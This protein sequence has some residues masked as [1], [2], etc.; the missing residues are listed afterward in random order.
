LPT[1][2]EQLQMSVFMGCATREEDATRIS[3]N[4]P[5]PS[6]NDRNSL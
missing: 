3:I 6:S 2:G 4:M 1:K 5:F